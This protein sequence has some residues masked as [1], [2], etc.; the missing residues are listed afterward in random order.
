M[1]K[2]LVRVRAGPYASKTAAREAL[3]TFEAAGITGIVEKR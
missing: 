3:K 1:E 2:N